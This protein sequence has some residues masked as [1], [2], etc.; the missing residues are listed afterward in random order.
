MKTKKEI[1][2]ELLK[3][4]LDG[5]TIIEISKILKISRNTVAVVLAELKG[6]ELIR[7]RPIGK[8]KLNY[9]KGGKNE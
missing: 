4:R 7:I 5:L 8:A 9:W 1:V 6:A 3:K 2:V